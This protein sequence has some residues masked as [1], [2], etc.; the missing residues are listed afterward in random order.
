MAE[1]GSLD[2]TLASLNS[3][4]VAVDQQV[5]DSKGLSAL[6]AAN[7]A[8]P[9]GICPVRSLSSPFMLF[10]VATVPPNAS[11]LL[12]R[13]PTCPLASCC[14]V[15]LLCTGLFCPQIILMQ[16][17]SQVL[18]K[19]CYHFLHMEQDYQAPAAQQWKTYLFG[20]TLTIRL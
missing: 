5:T 13:S 10:N 3:S 19:C 7:S 9:P 8:K 14:L 16:A 17:R 1:S 6:M 4:Q 20:R 12:C 2:N 15:A 11:S 18:F